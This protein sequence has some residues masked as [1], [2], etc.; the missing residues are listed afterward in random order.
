MR[1]I[2]LVQIGS[3]NL[4]RSHSI[5]DLEY[6]I[7]EGTFLL[8]TLDPSSHLGA[9]DAG[10]PQCRPVAGP[11]HHWSVTGPP[12]PLPAV[13]GRSLDHHRRPT[14]TPPPQPGPL[15]SPPSAATGPQ[16][17]PDHHRRRCRP[18]LDHSCRRTTT[19][20]AASRGQAI[21]GPPPPPDRHPP[22]HHL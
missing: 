10:I 19:I 8:R 1:T 15:P 16:P 7:L 20:A 12:L 14:P 17:S 18:L 11:P 22:L 13:A 6:S 9:C 3:P 4:N 2:G 21:A 5:H